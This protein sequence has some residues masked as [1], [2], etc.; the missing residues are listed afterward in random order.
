MGKKVLQF[1]GSFHQ[2]GSERQAVQLS[3]LLK[4]SGEFEVYIATLEKRGVLLKEV[5]A[6]GFDDIREYRITSFLSLGF[7]RQLYRCSRFLK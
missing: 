6:A 4:S 7:V 5:E 1:I 3:K 2:G